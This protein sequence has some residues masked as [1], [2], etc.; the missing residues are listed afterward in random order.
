MG[1]AS[2]NWIHWDNLFPGLQCSPLLARWMGFCQ[3]VPFRICHLHWVEVDGNGIPRHT[4]W[5]LYNLKHKSSSKINLSKMSTSK[6][7]CWVVSDL[8]ILVLDQL[9]LPRGPI[10]VKVA[11]ERR[12]GDRDG[13]FYHLRDSWRIILIKVS[14]KTCYKEVISSMA[15][16]DILYYSTCWWICLQAAALLL[17][18]HLLCVYILSFN[19]IKR[20]SVSLSSS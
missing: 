5:G 16:G 10:C 7:H 2:R 1:S 15:N 9:G 19:Y 6:S 3:Q 12:L 17:K 18:N 8:S 11:Y 13:Q 20:W 14:R 4:G